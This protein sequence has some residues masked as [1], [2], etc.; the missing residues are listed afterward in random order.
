VRWLRDGGRLSREW[1]QDMDADAQ[2]QLADTA[3]YAPL[4]DRRDVRRRCRLDNRLQRLDA[5]EQRA[6]QLASR[7]RPAN[8]ALAAGDGR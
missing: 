1:L 3:A 2:L 4:D 5:A 8:D 6:R 7:A